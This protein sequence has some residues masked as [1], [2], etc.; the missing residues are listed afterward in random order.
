M[1]RALMMFYTALSG[2][3]GHIKNFPFSYR[4][5]NTRDTTSNNLLFFYLSLGL[6]AGI[7]QNNH[8]GRQNTIA[9]NFRW[10]EFDLGRFVIYALRPLLEKKV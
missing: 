3:C 7:L 8:H 1:A 9:Q 6:H 2:V 10:Y 5:F 4:N